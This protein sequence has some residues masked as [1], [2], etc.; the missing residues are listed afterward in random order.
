MD[1]TAIGAAT[2]TAIASAARRRRR[3]IRRPIPREEPS[4]E[5]LLLLESVCPKLLK[6]TV[7]LLSDRQPDPWSRSGRQNY[8]RR[9][10]APAGNDDTSTPRRHL[11][12]SPPANDNAPPRQREHSPPRRDTRTR[13]DT[14]PQRDTRA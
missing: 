8:V 5:L 1:T 9:T 10:I 13:R 12:P 7:F 6:N 4:G 11:N 3:D 2:A 14:R